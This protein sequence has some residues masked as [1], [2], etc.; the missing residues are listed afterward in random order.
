[1]ATQPIIGQ[2]G[3]LPVIYS[4]Q[5]W[6]QQNPIYATLIIIVLLAYFLYEEG[7]LK[8]YLKF[9]LVPG[10][11]VCTSAFTSRLEDNGSKVNK[12]VRDDI[13]MSYFSEPYKG[14]EADRI[15][16]NELTALK[17]AVKDGG[18]SLTDAENQEYLTLYT[19]VSMASDSSTYAQQVFDD[20][21]PSGPDGK[22]IP[23]TA[24]AL[25]TAEMAAADVA[26]ARYQADTSAQGAMAATGGGRV[27]QAG[28]TAPVDYTG[29]GAATY[30][31]VESM[32]ERITDDQLRAS[33][34][35]H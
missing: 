10:T 27:I 4:G 9:K 15:R 16:L 5:S 31:A 7:Y 14:F 6:V 3:N 12:Y 23:S 32:T 13:R 20:Y 25:Y 28:S 17:A 26:S 1:M 8:F 21:N 24:C 29:S 34:A 2:V 35:F 33:L 19:K 18:R 22:P 11:A 30:K